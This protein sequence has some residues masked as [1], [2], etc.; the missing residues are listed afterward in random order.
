MFYTTKQDLKRAEEVLLRKPDMYMSKYLYIGSGVAA[1]TGDD[2]T[3][4]PAV[5]PGFVVDDL[6]SAAGINLYCQDKSG[7]VVIGKVSDNDADSVTFD[8]SAAIKE[9]D[10]SAAAGTDFIIGNTYYFYVLTPHASQAWGD[11]FGIVKNP[12]FS[13]EDEMATLEETE[14][15]VIAE[16]LI[17]V[18]MSITGENYNVGNADVQQAIRNTTTIGDQ[19][20]YYEMNGGFR[21]AARPYWRATWLGYLDN[22]KAFIMQYFRG[23]LHQ[24]GSFNPTG[25]EYTP[26]NWVLNPQGD[27][28][29]DKAVNAYKIKIE[30]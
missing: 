4:T 1:V 24:E 2:V 23:R 12:D 28:L 14:E 13:Q 19:T 21:P 25:E 5:S 9:S 7:N 29:R 15:G 3:L 6:I 22:G 27:P 26:F 18:N 17:R 10:G 20:S 8:A 11:Y 16:G 30:K